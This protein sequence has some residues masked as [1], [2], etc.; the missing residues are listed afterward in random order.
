[1]KKFPRIAEYKV[2]IIRLL[3]AYGFYFIARILFFVYNS[4]LIEVDGISDFLKLCYHGLAFD[5]TTILYT[6]GLF[7]IASVFPAIINTKKTYQKVLFFLYFATNLLMYSANF[8][9]FIYYRYTFSR[10]TRASLDTLENESNK[11]AL[12]FNFLLNYWH[13][14]L[15]FFALAYIWILLYKRTKVNHVTEKPTFKYFAAS[16]ASFLLIITL[17]IGGIRGDFKKSTRPINLLDAS[18]YVKMP[19]KPMSF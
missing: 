13:V 11:T 5:T 16:I 2:M 18:R 12:L 9:D 4:S 3:L 17:C 15:L 8:I 10:S 19:V 14:F 1:M 6:N 7:I